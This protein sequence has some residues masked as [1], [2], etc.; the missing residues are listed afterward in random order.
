MKVLS[1]QQVADRLGV[2]RPTVYIWIQANMFPNAYQ[3]S[4]QRKS[5]WVVPEED[6]I[7]FEKNRH[8]PVSATP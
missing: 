6:V 4:P 7:A 8:Q 3:K 2:S 5:P 1:T